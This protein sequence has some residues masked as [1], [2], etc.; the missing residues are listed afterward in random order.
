MASEPARNHA[1]ASI[2]RKWSRIHD[3]DR[4]KQRDMH[5]IMVACYV[6]QIK[7]TGRKY[8]GHRLPCVRKLPQRFLQVLVAFPIL[9]M[10]LGFHRIE[11]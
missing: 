4:T 6:L 8:V 11:F 1:D 2:I 3:A 5:R 7:V 10:F 9:T